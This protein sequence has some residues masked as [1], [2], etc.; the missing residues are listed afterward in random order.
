MSK[1]EDANSTEKALRATDAAPSTK[2][3][4]SEFVEKD[5]KKHDKKDVKKG[6]K[7]IVKEKQTGETSQ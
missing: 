7:G 2:T 4:Q 5:V 6:S 3:L 1:R